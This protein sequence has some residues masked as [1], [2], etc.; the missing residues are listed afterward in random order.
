M[1]SVLECGHGPFGKKCLQEIE[2][3]GQK[4]PLC[5]APPSY[6]LA[7]TIISKINES[8]GRE[9]TENFTQSVEQWVTHRRKRPAN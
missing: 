6:S 4:C 7:Q 9:E 5:A 2:S 3:G 8:E 1:G